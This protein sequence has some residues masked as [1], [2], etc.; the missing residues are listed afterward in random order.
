MEF[1]LN[2]KINVLRL[3]Q[4]CIKVSLE[5]LLSIVTMAYMFQKKPHWMEWSP[6]LIITIL[7]AVLYMYLFIWS[8]KC[9]YVKYNVCT[10][11]F[12][13]YEHVK[14]RLSKALIL[15]PLTLI[16]MRTFY[17]VL[18]N[19]GQKGRSSCYFAQFQHK[20]KI[21][22]YNIKAKFI[23]IHLKPL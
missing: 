9:K 18:W 12:K 17:S 4:V 19:F 21:K 22:I 8:K 7:H 20:A 13:K 6:L 23:W 16:I 3:N 10:W 14:T 5:C 11:W 2:K 15:W 1:I